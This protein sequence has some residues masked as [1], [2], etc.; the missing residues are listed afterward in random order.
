MCCG[1]QKHF[2]DKMC[3]I[4]DFDDEQAMFFTD[5]ITV[6]ED[7]E[8]WVQSLQRPYNVLLPNKENYRG[9]SRT[10]ESKRGTL[11][12]RETTIEE[13]AVELLMMSMADT[14]TGT[15]ASTVSLAAQGLSASMTRNKGFQKYQTIGDWGC[16]N[17]PTKSWQNG[18]DEMLRMSWK[19][20]MMEGPMISNEARCHSAYH[21]ID[22]ISDETTQAAYRLVQK[23]IDRLA[24]HT[25]PRLGDIGQRICRMDEII[26]ARAEFQNTRGMS[27]TDGMSARFLSVFLLRRVNAWAIDE[28]LPLINIIVDDSLDHYGVWVEYM[29]TDQYVGEQF[30]LHCQLFWRMLEGRHVALPDSELRTDAEPEHK[31]ARLD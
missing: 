12:R 18:W 4:I 19:H 21:I 7:L 8:E 15:T 1:S 11:P 10:R 17:T 5:D 2:Q 22:H 20:V 16:Y 31:R 13:F 26:H 23:Q 24:E 28:Q 29:P 25:S 27:L 3:T 9:D 6:V 14:F 30:A